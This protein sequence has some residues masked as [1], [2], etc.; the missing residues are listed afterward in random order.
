MVGKISL[1]PAA[2]ALAYADAIPVQGPPPGVDSDR[3]ARCSGPLI[4]AE[5]DPGEPA[6]CLICARPAVQARAPSG[7]EMLREGQPTMPDRVGLGGVG[8]E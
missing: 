1:G 2:E 6:R 4:Q 5:V 3:C 7:A 8:D